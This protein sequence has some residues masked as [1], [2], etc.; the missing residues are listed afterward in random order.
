[1]NTLEIQTVSAQGKTTTDEALRLFD[2][3]D[4]VELEFMFGQWRGSGLLK[5][6]Q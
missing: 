1:M 3:L 2:Q 5:S 6:I 4:T